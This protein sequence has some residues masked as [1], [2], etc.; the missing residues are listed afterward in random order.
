MTDSQET[1]ADAEFARRLSA[2]QLCIQRCDDTGRYFFY[3][4]QL[5]PF[6][7]SDNVSW[8]ECS[9]DGVVYSTTAI[10][11]K[12]DQGGD[13]NI[14]IVQLAEGPKMMSRVEGIDPHTVTIGLP[15]RAR[16]AEEQGTR[17]VVFDPA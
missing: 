10:S 3:P 5:S 7:G 17:L 8:R 13:Y 12:A 6:T 15:V 1:G 11:R 2:G 16:I 9:G 4:R 14:A